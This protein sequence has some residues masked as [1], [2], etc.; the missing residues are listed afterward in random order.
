M[1]RKMGLRDKIDSQ[2]VS[3]H[4]GRLIGTCE[5]ANKSSDF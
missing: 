5:P 1:G 3:E 4:V 2:L